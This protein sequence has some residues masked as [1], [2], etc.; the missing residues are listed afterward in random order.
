MVIRPC[1]TFPSP[2]LRFRTAGFPQYGS[3]PDRSAAVF[4]RRSRTAGLFRADD[5]GASP[6][7]Y[8]RTV[9]GRGNAHL[10]PLVQRPLARQQVILSRQVIAYYGL[11]RDSDP[12][13]PSWPY[14]IGR[15]VFSR[16]P[17]PE[18]S[19]FK[20]RV[21][22]SVPPALPRRSGGHDCCS[23]ARIGLHPLGTGSAPAMP[24]QKSVHGGNGFRGF[25]TFAYRCGP[26]RCQPF[27]DKDRYIRACVA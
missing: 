27:T 9:S 3:K 24:H 14:G 21:F 4:S 5:A 8:S 7:P 18:L 19:Q 17:R 11:I 13:P 25:R 6:A 26:D 16:R 15:R 1:T 23:S 22:R 10:H 2:S 12:L 20:L